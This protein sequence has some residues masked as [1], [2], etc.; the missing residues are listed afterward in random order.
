M[1]KLNRVLSIVIVL[2]SAMKERTTLP[3][4]DPSIQKGKGESTSL[5]QLTIETET[6]G[7]VGVRFP[8]LHR[9]IQNIF[10]FFSSSV[11]IGK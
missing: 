3:S 1:V 10:L 9:G 7:T 5:C 2:T 11:W 6:C 4:P 8:F